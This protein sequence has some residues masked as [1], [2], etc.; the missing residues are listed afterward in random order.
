MKVEVLRSRKQYFI[1]V[2]LSQL[3]VPGCSNTFSSLLLLNIIVL[4]LVFL[5]FFF[6]LIKVIYFDMGI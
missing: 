6:I 1:V 3:Q 2:T 5:L 4:L